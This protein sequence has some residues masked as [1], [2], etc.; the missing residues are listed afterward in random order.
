M[1][2]NDS[3]KW[4]TSLKNSF[5]CFADKTENSAD[6][7]TIHLDLCWSTVL[8]LFNTI[9]REISE[10]GL[11]KTSSISEKFDSVIHMKIITVPIVVHPK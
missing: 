2:S 1:I 4:S 7:S 8:I 10:M 11:A 3:I 6:C 5:T 9:G